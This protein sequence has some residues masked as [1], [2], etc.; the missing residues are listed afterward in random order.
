MITYDISITKTKWP[1]GAYSVE[2]AQI[3]D[4]EWGEIWQSAATSLRWAKEHARRLLNQMSG[5]DRQR[6]TWTT[7]K[8]WHQSIVEV[9][10]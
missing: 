3:I 10:A 7:D 2:V 9:D 8:G 4:D 6:L 1:G 5:L